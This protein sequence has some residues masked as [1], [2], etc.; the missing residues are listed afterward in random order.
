METRIRHGGLQ[1]YLLRARLPATGQRSDG[2]MAIVFDGNLR[3]LIHP[4]SLGDLVF[5]A[6]VCALPAQRGLADR[7]LGDVAQ[8]AA[9]RSPA[10]ADCLVLRGQPERLLLQQRVSVD[11]SAEEFETALAQF[12]NAL[13][14]WRAHTGSL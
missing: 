12:L 14:A 6:P 9:G 11:A 3:V 13:T 8:R 1:G 10:L 2:A 4:T 7:L 5:E